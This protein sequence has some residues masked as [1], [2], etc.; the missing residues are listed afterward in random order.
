[1]K[2]KEKNP[3]TSCSKKYPFPESA[4]ANWKINV[5]KNAEKKQE[6][7]LE[8]I[9]ERWMKKKKKKKKMETE[10]KKKTEDE[11]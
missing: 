8:V 7:E 11:H 9:L 2:T 1:M 10:K 4:E 6:G 3:L 5:K